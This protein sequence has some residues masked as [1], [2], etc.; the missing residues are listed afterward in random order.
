MGMLSFSLLQLTTFVSRGQGTVG[1]SSQTQPTILLESHVISKKAFADF[2]GDDSAF[3]KLIDA[4]VKRLRRVQVVADT[5]IS[6]ANAATLLREFDDLQTHSEGREN[7][8]RWLVGIVS[9][10]D[11]NKSINGT[12]ATGKAG[13]LGIDAIRMKTVYTHYTYYLYSQETPP[14]NIRDKGDKGKWNRDRAVDIL[15]GDRTVECPRLAANVLVVLFSGAPALT[16]GVAKTQTGPAPINLDQQRIFGQAL[17]VPN[18]YVVGN[19]LS[20]TS[21]VTWFFP[22]AG[23]S[24]SAQNDNSDSG[25]WGITGSLVAVQTNWS[26]RDTIKAVNILAPSFGLTYRAVEGHLKVRDQDTYAQI[27]PFIRYTVR[28]LFGDVASA[29]G[30]RLLRDAIG[31]DRRTY[32][33]LDVGITLSIN[34]VRLTTNIPVFFGNKIEGFSRGQLIA[35]FGL[36]ASI[37]INN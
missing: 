22:W 35:G 14:D 11:F 16:T 6:I 2:H 29:S 18:G 17:L 34:A 32:H 30:Q 37:P 9:D 10:G 24:G 5:S 15:D 13:S 27:Q 26:S 19:G 12:V 1:F 33:A 31:T 20:F 8:V 28:H 3:H 7:L 25:R 4:K 23:A 36:A 21:N